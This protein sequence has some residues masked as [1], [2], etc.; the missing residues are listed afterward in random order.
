MI[1]AT[2]SRFTLLDGEFVLG[3]EIPREL[4]DQLPDNKKRILI[5]QH[6]VEDKAI[7]ATD[8]PRRRGRPKG[9]RDSKPRR[10]QKF[11]RP[12]IFNSSANFEKGIDVSSAVTIGAG[13]TVTT[14]GITAG[15]GMTLNDGNM[16]LSFGGVKNRVQTSTALQGYGHCT[17][18]G[19]TATQV[20]SLGAPT[21]GVPVTIACLTATG[22]SALTATVTLAAGVSFYT[23]STAA[24]TRKAT[25]SNSAQC[26]YLMG[27]STTK[28]H[29]L[30]NIGSVVLGTT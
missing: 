23:T 22:S 26:L 17:V 8:A 27:T 18:S 15:G 9:A 1:V 28:Y 3:D 13:L 21:A 2:R 4:W 6:Y 10:R 29:V 11:Q 12:Y 30:N 25:F 14:G 20:Y 24:T 5:N 16:S 19:E 7:A